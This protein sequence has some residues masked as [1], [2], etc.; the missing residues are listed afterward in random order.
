MVS[1]AEGYRSAV[2]YMLL[3]MMAADGHRD[4]N[5]Y[6]YILRVAYEMGM[7][8]EDIASLSAEDMMKPADVPSDERERMT[9]L[10][11]LLF[12]MKT[13]GRVST[14]EE[15]LVKDLGYHLG[16]RIDLVSDLI[17]VIRAHH[18]PGSPSEAL[19]NEIRK[20]LN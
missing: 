6:L 4:K 14:E 15:N 12:M 1:L 17:N 13:D 19:L 20:Y 7:T 9:I 16:F 10:Y 3:R 8:Q 2:I 18:S 5:E 11:Y